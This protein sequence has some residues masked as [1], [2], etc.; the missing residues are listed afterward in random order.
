MK[1]NKRDENNKSGYTVIIPAFN[2]EENIKDAVN[3]TIKIFK[4][5]KSTENY[6]VLIIDDG[7]V[8]KTGSIADGMSN[9]NKRIKVI[10]NN[11]NLGLGKSVCRGIAKASEEFLTVFPG[12]NDMSSESLVELINARRQ[13][14]IVFSYPKDTSVRSYLRRFLSYLFVRIMNILFGLKLKYYNG[15][16]ICRSKIIKKMKLI[17]SGFNIY[18]E[19]KIRLIRAGYSYK[20]IPFQLSGRKHGKSKAFKLKNILRIFYTTIVLWRD[21]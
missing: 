4:K 15:P 16:F 6:E 13:A 5:S 3:N 14:D 21:Y 8:D 18:A 7:S 2:E 17:S 19:M 1:N 20:E 10:H 12:D 11:K 9:Q